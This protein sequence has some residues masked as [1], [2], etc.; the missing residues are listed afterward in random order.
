[1][2]KNYIKIAWRN[3]R[4]NKSFTIINVF[5][6]TLGI[7]CALLIFA[8]VHY[9]F[10]FDNFHRGEERIYRLVTEWQDD[11]VDHS[12][13]VPGPLGKSFRDDFS[14]DQYTARSINFRD[15]LVTLPGTP[16]RKKFNEENL[17][18]YTE[19]SY[20]SIFNFPISKGESAEVL[21]DPNTAIITEKIAKK[22]FGDS[23]PLGQ[24]IKINNNTDFT[25]KAILKDLPNNTDLQSEVFLSFVNLKDRDPELARDDAWN[26]VYSGTQCYTLLKEGISLDMAEKALRQTSE[27]HY[28]GRDAKV[29]N[30][31]L[32]PLK[33]IHFNPV[34]NGAINKNYLYALL[35]IGLLLLSTACI[36]FTNLA[37]AQAINR[38]K[39]I[40]IRKV[41]GSRQKQLFWQFISET[42]LI[43]LMSA[44]LA[45]GFASLL[46]PSINS[47]FQSEVRLNLLSSWQMPLFLTGLIVFVIF[48]S[49]FYPGLV[50]G[51]FKP[52][53]ALR[54]KITQREVGGFA[55]RRSLV[56][57]QFAISQLLIIATLIIARQ[58]HY[59]NN[60]DL[61]FDK[62]AIV[63][64][65]IPEADSDQINKKLTLKNRLEGTNG[66]QTV[67][68]NFQPPASRSN[69]TTSVRYDTRT[70]EERWS[71][72]L[73][74]ADNQY[75][76]TF[77]M[78]LA[79]GR[80]IRRS[81]TINEFLVNET[82][83][84]K[85][86][87]TS[88][89]EVIGKNITVNGTAYNGPIVGVVK[90][91]YNYSFRSEKDAICIASNSEEY[92]NCSIKVSS[93][94][95]ASTLASFEKIWSETYPDY[96]YSYQFMDD[97]VAQFYE[98]DNT[99]LKLI[100]AFT[101]VAVLIGCLGLYGLISFMAF[102][103]TKEIGV[104]K[105]LGATIPD[106]LWIFGK[107][108]I[109]LLIIAF[110][111]AAPI[112]W[113]S[114]KAY[115]Q[116]FSYKI[117]IGLNV[118]LLAIAITFVIAIITIGFRSIRAATVNPIKSLRS[119]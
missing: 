43:T 14:L 92:V 70:E 31:K 90:D 94:H 81:D 63:N 74:F 64:L 103:K 39:E 27:K 13:G 67:S 51:G 21:A 40:G 2:F 91:F 26:G 30:F 47:I 79:A 71:I 101:L 42:A 23:N 104:R 12:A 10:S 48:L 119:E 8:L 61:G 115:L 118:F 114:M 107:E 17:I 105:V 96:V 83:V 41:L 3:I 72:N 25:V 52:I 78:Q 29:W 55:L 68:L 15:M 60:T 113:W 73:K 54:S 100:Q 99:L 65:P 38:A 112:T 24:I 117:E 11:V 75:L 97:A 80:N 9:H 77:N 16:D 28:P 18:A 7:T 87:L 44:L 36:N 1:M 89:E 116:D 111:I 102:H 109:R 110:I 106:I 88:A 49:G 37:T 6:L 93:Q 46:L 34:Y 5:G 53:Q 32:Q 19:A 50:L 66:V 58:I 62:S 56:V 85:L 4:R 84:K 108:F 86:N 98:T 33:D 45:Y 35:F 69:R 22:Y 76:S 57:G 95:L 82:F 59:V 20:F